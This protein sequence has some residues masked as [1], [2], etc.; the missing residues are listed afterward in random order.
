MSS[1]CLCMIVKNEAHVLERCVSSVL[2]F[3][4][5]W[6][7][8]DTGSTDGTQDTVCKLL[9]GLPGKLVERPWRDFGHNRSEALDLARPLADYSFIID[10]DE[11]LGA[12]VGFSWPTLS[13][14]SYLL[15]HL[16][17]PTSYWRT[18]LI[19]NKLPWRYVG[20]LHE[21]LECPNAQ[22]AE[23]VDGPTVLVRYDGGRSKGLTEVEKYARDVAVLEAGLELEPDNARYVYYL[24]RTY[25]CTQQWGLAL[26]AYRRRATMGG[27][28]EE[29]FDSLFEI[30]RLHEQMGS[31]PNEVMAAY[32]NAYQQRPQ[33]AEPLC[34][35]ARYCRLQNWFA[36]ARMFA[37]AASTIRRP[38][39]DLLFVDED[40]YTWFSL[41]EYALGLYWAGEY[42]EASAVWQA[43]LDGDDLASIHRARIQESLGYARERLAE[44][45]ALEA[46]SW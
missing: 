35:L 13:G 2:P 29:V 18:A 12:P 28:E 5:A 15:R 36:L 16:S 8:V 17:G 14:D 34:W 9:A 11:E 19:A 38:T 40:V 10:A 4:D 30:A 43:L 6:L 37:E 45:S 22:P 33:R 27:Y 1:V 39:D 24:A 21:Y 7:V 44:S 41:D 23:K 46:P 32:L 26:M 20:V 31:P 25:K 3:I 42:E